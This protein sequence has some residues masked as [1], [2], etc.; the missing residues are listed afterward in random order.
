MSFLSWDRHGPRAEERELAG[1]TAGALWLS[2]LPMVGVALVLP[3]AVADHWLLVLVAAAPAAAWG[4][5]CLFAVP[6]ERV[7]TP[8]VFHVPSVIAVPFIGLLVVAT[9]G[10]H[11]PLILT[12]LMLLVFGAYFYPPRV[13]LGYMVC[14][15]AIMGLPLA[16]EAGAVEAGLI[17][18]TWVAA[19]V[20]AA[21]G[22]VVMVGK[23]QL[24]ALR[25]AAESLSLHDSLTGL[26]NRRALEEVLERHDAETRRKESLGFL[27]LDL[28]NFKE[29][30]TRFGMQGGDLT[31]CAVAGALGAVAREEQLLV[32]LGGDEFAI[33]A[34]GL[35]PRAMERL[36]ERALDAVRDSLIDVEHPGLHI[37]ASA[38]WA[39]CPHDADTAGELVAVADLALRA[40]KLGGKEQAR[41]PLDW[42]SHPD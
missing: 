15:V 16:Y 13:A 18:Q 38:G 2:V 1:K 10:T 32:R 33:V 11:S 26:A 34:E 29:V 7:T 23:R 30:N 28:D 24:L 39:V 36:A 40:A 9:G 4:L 8:L 5:A 25:D 20:Y 35:P 31:L 17:G 6:W 12:P 22:G 42:V 19:V 37:S 21:V 41:G 27:L 14:C 3:G